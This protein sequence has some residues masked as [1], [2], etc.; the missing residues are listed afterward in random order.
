[1]PVS[2][3]TK[4]GIGLPGLLLA[5]LVARGDLHIGNLY[6][7]VVDQVKAG[8]LQVED[9]QRFSKIQTHGLLTQKQWHDQHQY[10]LVL[11]LLSGIDA[12]GTA[13][14]AKKHPDFISRYAVKN[15]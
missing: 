10:I 6:N 2:C 12:T 7:T 1:M 15:L 11:G 3:C 13:W 5:F 14:V 8:G 9:H 4:A